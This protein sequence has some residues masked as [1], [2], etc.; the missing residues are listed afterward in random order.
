MARGK[1]KNKGKGK[2]GGDPRRPTS[3]TPPDNEVLLAEIAVRHTWAKSFRSLLSFVGLA[4]VVLAM[5][6]VANALAGE[7]T[8][9]HV[10]VALGLT[11][12]V[13]V[14]GTG[15]AAWGNSHR[16]RANRLEQRNTN[17]SRDGKE[18]QKRLRDQGLS[19]A[20]SRQLEPGE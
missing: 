18:L 4:L 11:A 17:L 14:A 20:V 1:A 2:R 9:L 7:Q 12:S 16:R 10:S 5:W 3:R 6:P 19:D 8:V 13:T 15:V